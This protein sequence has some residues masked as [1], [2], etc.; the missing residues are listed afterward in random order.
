MYIDIRVPE[1]V[2]TVTVRAIDPPDFD[3]YEV[4]ADFDDAWVSATFGLPHV[5]HIN[6]IVLLADLID[7]FSYVE[8][9]ERQIAIPA[10]EDIVVDTLCMSAPEDGAFGLSI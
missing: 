4:L 1:S 9:V 2:S 5:Q 8:A 7:G 6:D 3:L 10:S